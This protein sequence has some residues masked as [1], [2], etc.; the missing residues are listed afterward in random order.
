MNLVDFVLFFLCPSFLHRNTRRI[1]KCC[2]VI[3]NS[4]HLNFKH[5]DKALVFFN[6][7]GSLQFSP[8]AGN[9][10]LAV[11][12]KI[13]TGR[14]FTERALLRPRAQTNSYDGFHPARRLRV[15]F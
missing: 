12:I 3:I 11:A 9:I 2:V 15:G 7:V 14:E 5:K 6:V 13:F 8:R 4:A 10:V 1:V